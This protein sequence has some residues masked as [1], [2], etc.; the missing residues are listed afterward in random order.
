M[1][2]AADAWLWP[3]KRIVAGTSQSHGLCLPQTALV[4]QLMTSVQARGGGGLDHSALLK[5]AR[6]LN[7]DG[8]Q[9]GRRSR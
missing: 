7:G 1:S 5:G 2:L 4:S 3:S 6:E 8:A 9:G